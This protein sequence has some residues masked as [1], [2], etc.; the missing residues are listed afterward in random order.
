MFQLTEWLCMREWYYRVSGIYFYMNVVLLLMNASVCTLLSYK[1]RHRVCDPWIRKKQ[2]TFSKWAHIFL[3]S[4]TQ[5]SINRW[6]IWCHIFVCDQ[7]SES[8]KQRQRLG[9]FSSPIRAGPLPLN[10]NVNINA[11]HSSTLSGGGA[12]WHSAA[13]SAAVT[14]VFT[15]DVTF[16]TNDAAIRLASSTSGKTRPVRMMSP[17]SPTDKVA[18]HTATK[19]PTSQQRKGSIAEVMRLGTPQTDSS[20][21]GDS[22][23]N[24][25]IWTF[26]TVA[27]VILYGSGVLPSS[28]II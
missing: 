3:V 20:Q 18:P 21:R 17:M 1:V 2:I 19:W 7:L 26:V 23:G 15:S 22:T 11:L 5:F 16:T 10:A 28:R 25:A 4:V 27:F 8:R 14:P 24:G 9:L 13:T 12:N 6:Y